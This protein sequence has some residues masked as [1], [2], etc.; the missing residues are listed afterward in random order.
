MIV[1]RRAE[2]RGQGKER[3][4]QVSTSDEKEDPEP[5]LNMG[6]DGASLNE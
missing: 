3:E 1:H 6:H 5:K 4:K 2:D